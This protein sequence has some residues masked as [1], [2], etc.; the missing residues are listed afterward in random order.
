[1]R[2]TSIEATFRAS[3]TSVVTAVYTHDRR[4]MIVLECNSLNPLEA[5][6]LGAILLHAAEW[7]EAQVVET[8]TLLEAADDA[9]TGRLL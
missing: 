2:P 8:D 6:K 4:Q 9:K 3:P 5:K 7:L 1:M